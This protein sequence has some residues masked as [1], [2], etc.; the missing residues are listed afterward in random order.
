MRN[1]KIVFLTLVVSVLGFGL[2]KAD[3]Y[4][5]YQDNEVSD[6]SSGRSLSLATANHPAVV[7][8]GGLVTLGLLGSTLALVNAGANAPS[9]RR[10]SYD[11]Y[12][13]DNYDRQDA[14][15][16]GNAIYAQNVRNFEE[17][18]FR[19]AARKALRGLRNMRHSSRRFGKALRRGAKAMG[20]NTLQGVQAVARSTGRM[21]KS[22]G[23]GMHAMAKTAGKGLEKVS[24]VARRG[25]THVGRGLSRVGLRTQRFGRK[26]A[27]VG[28]A[29]ARGLARVGQSYRRNA[30]QARTSLGHRIYA[31][32]E[33]ISRVGDAVSRGYKNYV[34][35]LG[36]AYQRSI[37]RLGQVPPTLDNAIQDSVSRIGEMASE[38]AAK[39]G[40]LATDVT[41]RVSRVAEVASD[42][43]INAAKSLSNV[44]QE[45]KVQD[46]F[47]QAMCYLSTPYLSHNEVRRRKRA[48][49]SISQNGGWQNLPDSVYDDVQ[50]A[51][52]RDLNDGYRQN[53]NQQF[54]DNNEHWDDCE[55]FECGVAT[56][57]RKVIGAVRKFGD[58]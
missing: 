19:T 37:R 46:C 29:A 42:I 1:V 17:K 47:L 51:E 48:L 12:Y 22:A 39:L 55:V 5:N 43:P 53:G 6:E 14:I 27:G 45:K 9:N 7:A 18:T 52:Y 56:L 36:T 8:G 15:A 28:V 13:Y 16:Q 25:M 2:C 10:S 4:G 33:G 24:T 30:I 31:A 20:H 35:R 3:D 49:N 21:A 26:L 54:F 11:D 34:D 44:A 32:G 50:Q 41:D 58:R 40:G 38:S 23:K 57:G